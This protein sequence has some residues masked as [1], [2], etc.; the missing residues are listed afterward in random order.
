MP[1]LFPG[2]KFLSF[3]AIHSNFDPLRS[4]VALR[5]ALAASHSRPARSSPPRSSTTR[6]GVL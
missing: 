3:H 1:A 6:R 5:K 4:T 2:A